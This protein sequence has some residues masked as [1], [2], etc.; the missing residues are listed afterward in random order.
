MKRDWELIR[1]ILLKLEENSD[2]TP[3]EA[4]IFK[5]KSQELVAYHYKILAQ[6]ELIEIEDNSSLDGEDYC[7]KALTWQGH[8]FL[9]KIRNDT[10]WN[11]SKAM[12]KNKGIDLSFDVLKSAAT[13]IISQL[14]P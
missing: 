12:L 3:L 7:A 2:D 4:D 13:T 1:K 10:V 14:I 6:A 11:K 9:D 5:N 8:E